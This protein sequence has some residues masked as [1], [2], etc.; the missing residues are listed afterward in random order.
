[1][2]LSAVVVGLQVFML[3]VHGLT[4]VLRPVPNWLRLV[5]I[6]GIARFLHIENVHKDAKQTVRKKKK[7]TSIGRKL[8]RLRHLLGYPSDIYHIDETDDDQ[9][10]VYSRWPGENFADN[11]VDDQFDVI[12]NELNSSS[13]LRFLAREAKFFESVEQI[14]IGENEQ[15]INPYYQ[16]VH[17]ERV[18][19]SQPQG[20]QQENE[21]L[22]RLIQSVAYMTK[23]ERDETLTEQIA[24]E[25]RLIAVVFDRLAFWFFFIFTSVSTFGLLVWLPLTQKEYPNVVPPSQIEITTS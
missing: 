6:D 23:R 21:L 10:N 13:R 17:S 2:S 22:L 8:R 7:K 1:M 9:L 18:F 11:L 14:I 16:E 20:N 4:P 15:F 12:M 3:N 19:R 25:W 5:V 24:N